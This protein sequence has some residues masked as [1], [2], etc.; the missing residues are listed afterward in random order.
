MLAC[1][2]SS[3]APCCVGSAASRPVALASS[4]SA[5]SSSRTV[6]GS[7]IAT[8]PLETSE[9]RASSS[10]ASDAISC[11]QADGVRGGCPV[12]GPSSLRPCSASMRSSSSSHSRSDRCTAPTCMGGR[13]S[14]LGSDGPK[15]DEAGSAVASASEV[16]TREETQGCAASQCM[17]AQAKS[18]RHH[19]GR[20]RAALTSRACTATR[21]AMR[22][23]SSPE[24]LRGKGVT[25]QG[26]GG[27]KADIPAMSTQI[28]SACSGEGLTPSRLQRLPQAS[29][30]GGGAVAA[31]LLRRHEQRREQALEQLRSELGR[32]RLR[33]RGRGRG[34]C[35]PGRRGRREGGGGVDGAASTEEEVRA[36]QAHRADGRHELAPGV[37][38]GAVGREQRHAQREEAEEGVRL[39]LDGHRLPRLRHL[40]RGQA[41][42]HLLRG[43]TR[44]RRA[45]GATPELGEAAHR[46]HHAPQAEPPRHGQPAPLGRAR[47]PPAAVAVA[48]V[49]AAIAAAAVAP[50]QRIPYSGGEGGGGG[51]HNQRRLLGRHLLDR[52]CCAPQSHST[53]GQPSAVGWVHGGAPLQLVKARG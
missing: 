36:E 33:R 3:A 5:S 38:C 8:F 28:A 52:R 29:E 17:R 40:L 50:Q 39:E 37:R 16:T 12:A 20:A 31:Q 6:S 47:G 7:S 23:F 41:P 25:F 51:E 9:A 43:S 24:G 27:K 15:D 34:L 49:T 42:L 18:S 30:R 21:P 45:G 48:A 26:G 1:C 32:A 14:A 10:C 44:R 2:A 46:A 22:L 13:P 19:A 11:W 4:C 53:I 35:A